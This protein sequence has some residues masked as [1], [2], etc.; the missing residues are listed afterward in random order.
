[1][2][3]NLFPSHSSKSGTGDFKEDDLIKL[4][5][6]NGNEMFVPKEAYRNKLL[7]KQVKDAWDNSDSLYNVI[8]LALKDGFFDEIKDA[9]KRLLEIDKNTE[10]SYTVR[11]ILLMKL[12]K[13]N[14]AN[15]LLSD[16][17]KIYGKNGVIMTNLAKTYAEQGD[18]D[19]AQQILWES[20]T[21]DPN[22]DNGLVWWGALFFE[23]GGKKA[24]IEAMKKVAS[25]NGS[26]RPQLFIAQYYLE[27]KELERAKKL[28]N[29]VF[30]IAQDEPDAMMMISGDLGKNGY[31]QESI[32]IIRP[33]YDPTRHGPYTGLNLL[34]SYSELGDYENGQQLLT[35]L[36]KLNRYDIKSNLKHYQQLFSKLRNK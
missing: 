28:Y 5:D 13:S 30:S 19:T 8:I 20:L 16:Y 10:R 23:R 18:L 12:G 11:S 21:I 9:T 35:E 6:K 17:I 22:Q 7:P 4:Y 2:L 31:I 32:S 29:E 15:K 26:W 3:K 34:Q 27:Q 14:K 1:M 25:V 36:K 33:K 24:F